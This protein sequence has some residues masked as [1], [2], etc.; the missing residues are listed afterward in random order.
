MKISLPLKRI[1]DRKYKSFQLDHS[2]T[3]WFG[4]RLVV[5]NQEKLKKQILNEAH[6]S[7]FSIHLGSNKMYRDV[8]KR[9]CWKGLKQ[10]I[11][12]FVAEC[13]VCCRVKVE[14]LKPAE[15][16]KPL[17][18]P[19]QKW[20]DITM[21]FIFGVPR[22]SSG[23]YS[24][25][26]IIDR[27]TK[28]AHFLPIKVTYLV[29]KY[30]ELYL[31]HIVCLNAIPKIIVSDRDPQFMSQFWDELHKAMVAQHITHRPEVRWR[32]LTKSWRIC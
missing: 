18:I 26:V 31:A 19:S 14:H 25:W 29:S 4:K 3:L 24:I 7:L 22:T 28:S 21:D 32:E 11:A 13:D 9:F 30:A 23:Y 20:E 8:R 15:T 10:D 27:L 17:P 12:R 1:D 6:E 16:L 5:P 2:N